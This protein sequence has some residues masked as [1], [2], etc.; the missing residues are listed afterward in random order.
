M[1]TTTIRGD[2]PVPN[3]QALNRFPEDFEP[4]AAKWDVVETVQPTFP[5]AL[6]TY[7][8]MKGFTQQDVSTMTGIAQPVI[9]RLMKDTQPTAVTLAK[10]AQGMGVEITFLSTGEVRIKRQP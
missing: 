5:M 1:P 7:V 4:V 9:G 8:S 10:L 3:W 2:L 6:T